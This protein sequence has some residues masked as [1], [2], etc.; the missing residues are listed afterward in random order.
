MLRYAIYHGVNYVDTAWPYHEGDLEFATGEILKDGYR[1][2]V[3]LVT[4]LPIS[5]V[6]KTE[7][8]DRLL[9][10]QLNKL[11]TEYLDIYLVHGIDKNRWYKARDLNIM[12]EAEKAKA[13]GRIKYIGFSFHGGADGFREIIDSYDWDVVQIQYNLMDDNNQATRNG[14]EYAATK[15]IPVV[16]MEPL[17]G[18]KLAEMNKENQTIFSKSSI[19]RTPADWALQYIWN[20]PA[21]AVVLSGMSTM[22]QFK[23]NIE[24]ADRSGINSLSEDE[25]RIIN[26]LKILYEKKTK[27]PCTQCKYCMPCPN[28]VDIPGCFGVYNDIYWKG[29][30]DDWNKFFYTEF[31]KPNKT[32]T[33]IGYGPAELCT[34]CNICVEKC[35]QNII[36]PDRLA[37]IDGIF[38][39]GQPLSK[40]MT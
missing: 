18:G 2:K 26:E 36:I 22:Q 35:P 34:K 33:W 31:S 40:Y 10:T 24:S 25:I 21:V 39:D 16:I 6:H 30:V 5:E 17:R 37:E 7:D 12:E 15:G 1:E 20:H 8:F 13:D 4:K 3:K 14:L 19:Q 11:Q 9:N 23:E 32:G 38:N 27:V 29:E 28:G